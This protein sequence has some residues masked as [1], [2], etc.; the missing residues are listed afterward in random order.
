[1]IEVR[2]NHE[3]AVE[4]VIKIIKSANMHWSLSARHCSG[5]PASV[6]FFIPVRKEIIIYILYMREMKRTEVN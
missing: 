1:M 2:R 4:I 6:I 3:E 5:S